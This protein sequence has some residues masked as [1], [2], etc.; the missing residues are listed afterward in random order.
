[1]RLARNAGALTVLPL[2][3]TYRAVVDVHGGD[4]AA[5][6]ALVDEADAIVGA[7]GRPPLAST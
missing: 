3:L 4:F 5:A 1:M 2:A 7:T 6:S